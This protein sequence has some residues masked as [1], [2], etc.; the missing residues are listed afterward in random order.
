MNKTNRNGR[1]WNG[2]FVN[3][4]ITDKKVIGEYQPKKL[5]KINDEHLHNDKFTYKGKQFTEK[6]L[7][8]EFRI[9]QGEPVKNY[10]P[11]IVD[12]DLFD[13][14]QIYRRKRTTKKM[15]HRVSFF[16]NIFRKLAVCGECGHF[17]HYAPKGRKKPHHKEKVYLKCR[18]GVECGCTQKQMFDY[19]IVKHNILYF[20]ESIDIN[21][22]FDKKNDYYKSLKMKQSKIETELENLKKQIELVKADVRELREKGKR[23]PAFY[24]EEILDLEDQINEKN[25]KLREIN[26]E[27]T[28][29]AK[30]THQNNQNIKDLV[31][32]IEDKKAVEIRRKLN[33]HLQ[34]F[35]TNISFFYD[36]K[37]KRKYAAILFI[38]QRRKIL[39]VHIKLDTG[40]IGKLVAEFKPQV[41]A[42]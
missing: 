8:K 30:I 13:A 26:Q 23:T 29:K 15:G 28:E 37:T 27:L 10:Y 39:P 19:E 1:E 31:E 18:K 34:T 17:L 20:C 41:S 6:D 32:K 42:V 14:V 36:Y 24:T 40:Y 25:V 3:R 33:E 7:G 35:I 5:M 22:F 21:I 11:Q 38:D 9:P 2:T 16:P 12:N 4:I